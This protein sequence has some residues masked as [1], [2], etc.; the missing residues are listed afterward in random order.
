[1]LARY[2]RIEDIPSDGGDWDVSVRGPARLAETLRSGLDDALLFRRLA[3]LVRDA[4]VS[5][6][7]DALEWTGARD[8][9]DLVA[10]ILDAPD[11]GPRARRLAAER[12]PPG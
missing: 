1:M 4:P 5:A 7:V 11:L 2:G 12:E 10:T 3:T 6:R 9:F 8:D